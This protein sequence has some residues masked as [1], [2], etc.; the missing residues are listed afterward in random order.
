MSDYHRKLA[1]AMEQ[2]ASGYDMSH[3]I[4]A[5]STRKDRV[6]HFAA[7]LASEDVVD[8]ETFKAV[9]DSLHDRT[10]EVSRLEALVEE[11][12]RTN[13]EL[14]EDVERLEAAVTETANFRE[15]VIGVIHDYAARFST[16]SNVRQKAAKQIEDA[17]RRIP[18][19]GAL[20]AAELDREIRYEIRKRATTY[21]RKLAEVIDRASFNMPSTGDRRRAILAVLASEGVVDPETMKRLLCDKH[22]LWNWSGCRQCEVERLEASLK[23]ERQ[24]TTGMSDRKLSTEVE[25]L[26]AAL[27]EIAKGDGA[28]NRD[29]LTHADNC[30]EN[31]K[32]I[33]LAAMRSKGDND[34]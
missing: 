8:P 20:I 21:H 14:H 27:V 30:I 17:V 13:C 28:F 1:E 22:V 10:D 6:D 29:R 5:K 19:A 7:V 33:A 26:K 15:Q 34:D 24:I 11:Q 32:S 2:V 25:R 3:G 12:R 31:M 18:L 23:L 16:G 9:T 4:T